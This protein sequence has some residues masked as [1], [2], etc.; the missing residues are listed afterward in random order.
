MYIKVYVG[1]VVTAYPC[2]REFFS[3]LC[4]GERLQVT[5]LHGYTVTRLH[6]NTVTR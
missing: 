5:R 4:C 6:G 3:V 2:V 1:V